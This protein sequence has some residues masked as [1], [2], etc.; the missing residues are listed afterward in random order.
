MSRRTYPGGQP[1]V[2]PPQQPEAQYTPAP[3]L[4]ESPDESPLV[5]SR[6]FIA[7]LSTILGIIV[8]TSLVIG[9][10]GKYFFVDRSEYAERALR[11]S[12]DRGK[13]QVVLGKFETTMSQ[14]TG[15]L[16]RQEKALDRMADTVRSIELRMPRD[17]K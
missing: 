14:Q 5:G 11:E 10:T 17:R 6:T 8:A 16:D 2:M 9:F 12:E 7:V 13:L 4:A 3:V 15:T 1:I